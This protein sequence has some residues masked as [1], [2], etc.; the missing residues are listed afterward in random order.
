MFTAVFAFVI[1]VFVVIIATAIS[2]YNGLISLKNQVDRGWANIDV[3]LKQ[4]YDE[5]PQLIQIIEQYVQHEKAM[6]QKVADARARYGSATTTEDKIKASQE[7]SFV[8]KGIVAIGE[9]YP[10]LKSN[11]NFIQIQNRLSTLENN[12]ADRR[13][14]YNE[15]VTNYNTRT[16]QF[17]DVIFAR[18]LNFQEREFFKVTENEKQLP[19]LKMNLGA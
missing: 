18:M 1:I 9:A 4:R 12:L 10:D 8:L 2:V 7:M 3:I 17:P 19:N 16:S 11:A 15:C 14:V 5:I 13:E 6:I